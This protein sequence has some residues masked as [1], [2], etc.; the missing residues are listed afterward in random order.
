VTRLLIPPYPFQ[1]A[2]LDEL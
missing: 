1:V 2:T